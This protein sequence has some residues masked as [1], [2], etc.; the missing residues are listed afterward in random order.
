MIGKDPRTLNTN[1]IDQYSQLAELPTVSPRHHSRRQCLSVWR[2]SNTVRQPARATIREGRCRHQD[3][4]GNAPILKL[5]DSDKVQLQDHVTVLGYPGAADTFNSGLLSS[6]S[7][8]EA[9]INDGKI[10]ARKTASSGA[11]IL[12]TS[13]PATHGNSGG[14]VLNDAQRGNRSPHVSGR[15]RKWSGSLGVLIHRALKYGDGVCEECR[16]HQ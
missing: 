12:Q 6:K 1:Y 16:R 5:S 4:G 7:G 10:S 2:S 11:P 14:P 15:H 8:L 3:R 13:T 9:T